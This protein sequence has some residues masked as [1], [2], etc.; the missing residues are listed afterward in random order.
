MIINY[1]ETL[2]YY[3]QI[4]SFVAQDKEKRKLV[5][6]MVEQCSE[7]DTFLCVRIMDKHLQ[8]L[9]EGELPWAVAFHYPCMMPGIDWYYCAKT[10]D[11]TGDI[12]VNAIKYDDIPTFWFPSAE[13]GE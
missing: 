7:Y 6:V 12:N 11:L 3:D 9:I 8:R 1:I 2:A 5:C 13:G 4:L 10:T